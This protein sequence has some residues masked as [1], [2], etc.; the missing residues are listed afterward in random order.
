MK[1]TYAHRHTL[2]ECIGGTAGIVHCVDA[3]PIVR[4]PIPTR[5]SHIDRLTYTVMTRLYATQNYYKKSARKWHEYIT[6]I[7]I[8]LSG[9]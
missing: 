3:L 4:L 8:N 1:A 5:P 7:C 6:H 2:D 9:S